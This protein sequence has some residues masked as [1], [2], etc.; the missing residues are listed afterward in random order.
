M[1]DLIRFNNIAASQEGRSVLN[2]LSFDI[3]KNLVSVLFSK[4]YRERKLIADILCG[5]GEPDFGRVS[6]FGSGAKKGN[7]AERLKRAVHYVRAHSTMVE[8]LTVMENIL[9]ADKSIYKYGILREK[10][11]FEKM[12]YLLD[13]TGLDEEL[14]F[15]MGKDATRVE[16]HI[17]LACIALVR[18]SELIVF[19]NG[20]D[21]Y[22]EQDWQLFEG[23]VKKL[24]D[25]GFS[26]LF[27]THKYSR[28]FELSQKIILVRGGINV[29]ACGTAPLS[30]DNVLKIMTGADCG[31]SQPNETQP[32]ESNSPH[33]RGNSGGYDFSLKKGSA[34]GILDRNWDA[35][36]NLLLSLKGSGRNKTNVTVDGKQIKVN[37]K[38]INTDVA[39]IDAQ[40]IT[41]RVFPNMNLYENITC[42]VNADMDYP[43][44][45]LNERSRFYLFRHILTVLRM[46]A[47][48]DLNKFCF[49]ESFSVQTAKWACTL[50][51]CMFFF[52]PQQYYDDFTIK[53]FYSLANCL[54][55]EGI[56]VVVVSQSSQVL[57]EICKTVCVFE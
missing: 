53:E 9:L 36:P 10:I 29:T 8:S 21:S 46:D 27:I 35:A 34:L 39:V 12:K 37:E 57:G 47:H 43:L 3:K 50:P 14:F 6:L 33:F 41:Q 24:T 19:E 48:A 28:L 22:S 54:L 5:F 15:K 45:I 25:L 32:N 31:I 7:T 23:F 42:I 20:M 56:A 30:K 51:K 13:K 26:M 18:K 44:G 2:Y 49:K 16:T 17:A 52:N 1:S 55:N 4:D 38:G 40:N 11:L